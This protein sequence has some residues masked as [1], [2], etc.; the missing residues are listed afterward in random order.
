[1]L[2]PKREPWEPPRPGELLPEDLASEVGEDGTDGP[3]DPECERCGL[4]YDREWPGPVCL[5]CLGD[6]RV[7]RRNLQ[8]RSAR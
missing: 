8:Q 4:T 2:Q 7:G 1:V 6:L 5:G 3:P